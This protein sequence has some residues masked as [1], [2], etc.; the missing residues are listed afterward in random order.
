MLNIIK[1]RRSTRKFLDTP[2]SNDDIRDILEAGM[3]APSAMNEKAWQFVILEG[4]IMNTFL[5]IN[6]NTPKGAP[7]GILICGDTEKEKF[8]DIYLK[9]CS[10]ATQNMLLAIHSKNLGAVWTEIFAENFSQVRDLLNLPEFL[11][12]FAFIPIGYTAEEL[13]SR[14]SR[15]DESIVHKNM[16]KK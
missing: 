14:E 6:T 12:P 3:H 2:I 15:Y 4:D 11:N 13:S 16:Y 10:A 8:K 1:D 7:V 9:D 5:S